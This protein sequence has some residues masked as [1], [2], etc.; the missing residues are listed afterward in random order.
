MIELAIVIAIIA[1][2]AAILVPN[3]ASSARNRKYDP[4]IS[5]MFTEISTREE[6]YK[7]EQGN[8][9]YLSETECP[10]SPIPDGS[11]F[12]ANCVT[13][14]STWAQLGVVPTDHSIRC[15]YQVVTGLPGTTP[16][17]PAPCTSAGSATPVI[18]SW[19][20]AIATCD[21]DASSSTTDAQFCMSSWNADSLHQRQNYGQ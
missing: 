4:E 20:Y 16:S 7:A 21:M 10:A 11:D 19:Y 14:G 9:A 13:S 3:W 12:N 1:I 8:G 5:A 15:T 2:L 17:A 6:Q 18:G